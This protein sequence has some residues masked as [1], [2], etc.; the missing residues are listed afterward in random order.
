MN[1]KGQTLILK[2]MIAITI[3]VVVLA[4]SPLMKN[5]NDDSRSAPQM[6][7]DNDA[8]SDF[9]KIACISSDASLFLIIAISLVSAFI[10]FSIRRLK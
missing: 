1:N 10:L 7:C 3:I 2:F 5:I 6:D 4:M 8:I 9:D